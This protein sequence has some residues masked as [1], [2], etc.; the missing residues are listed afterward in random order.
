MAKRK[1][2]RH[3][4]LAGMINGTFS[5][6]VQVGDVL[7]GALASLGGIELVKWYYNEAKADTTM[8][9]PPAVLVDHP[10]LV[11]LGLGL[12]VSAA[13]GVVMKG[14]GSVAGKMLGSV[15]AGGTVAGVAE[16]GKSVPSLAGFRG[17]DAVNLSGFITS[18]RMNGFRGKDAV[19]LSAWGGKDAVNLGDG[20]DDEEESQGY[21][22]FITSDKMS[23]LAAYADDPRFS[24]L[25]AVV[26]RNDDDGISTLAGWGDEEGLANPANGAFRRRYSGFLTTD[27]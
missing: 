6:G 17:K 15:L 13:L 16:L 9:Q 10:E 14:K 24:D 18:D 26:S 19:S 11:G 4:G 21:D 8:P 12:G 22:G 25:A 27:R 7:I 5:Q 2:R 3:H 1:H 20:E 23:G